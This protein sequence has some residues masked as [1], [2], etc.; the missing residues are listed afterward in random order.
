MVKYK[1]ALVFCY[2]FM[3]ENVQDV[4]QCNASE[5][6]CQ[7]AHIE[8]QCIS[9]HFT[10]I[11]PWFSS[12]PIRLLDLFYFLWR[13][14]RFG[15]LIFLGRDVWREAIIF[16][17]DRL[18]DSVQPRQFERGKMPSVIFGLSLDWG[19]GIVEKSSI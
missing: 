13:K 12:L 8:D 18:D 15:F 19:V 10:L 14:S 16:W 17:A 6:M 1:I 3:V 11:R 2:E 4:G 9:A 5:L 7:Q